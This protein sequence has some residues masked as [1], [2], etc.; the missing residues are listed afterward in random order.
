MGDFL[1][2]FDGINTWVGGHVFRN[3]GKATQEEHFE[4]LEKNF[5]GQR[6]FVDE[7]DM[8]FIPR[9]PAGFSELGAKHIDQRRHIPRSPKHLQ[10]TLELADEYRTTDMIDIIHYNAWGEGTQIEPGTFE[11]GPY[12]EES[13]GTAYLDV[14][15]EFQQP[16]A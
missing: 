8:E 16:N 3:D 5:K 15:E 12:G 11:H 7:H 13:Y 1:P 14:V 6:D 9:A 4:F 10:A 2:L